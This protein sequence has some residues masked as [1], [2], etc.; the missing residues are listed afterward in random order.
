MKLVIKIF[1]LI[2]LVFAAVAATCF[3]TKPVVNI[4]GAYLLST[5]QITSILPAEIKD[6]VSEQ[7]L[8]DAFKD[9]DGNEVPL[10]VPLTFKLDASI[11]I[12]F[13]DKEGIK[14]YFN[15]TIENTVSNIVSKLGTP[16]HNLAVIIAKKTANKTIAARIIFC[17]VKFI[18][19][20][21]AIFINK[22]Y[23]K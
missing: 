16:I 6:Q 10:E 11:V 9:A 22:F 21:S 8:K 20:I 4:D 14:N 19:F 7:E 18:L 23:N 2:Y 13:K 12:H 5:E 17:L 3:I 15:T 1:N